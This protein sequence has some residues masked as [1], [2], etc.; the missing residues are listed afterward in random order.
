MKELID[1]YKKYIDFL[2]RAY[3][4]VFL[5]ANTHGYTCTETEIKIGQQLRDEIK[6]LEKECGINNN[7]I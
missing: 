7:N 1:A 4:D 3:D 2:G 6:K 5:F